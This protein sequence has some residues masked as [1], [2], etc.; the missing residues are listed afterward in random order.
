MRCRCGSGLV[1]SASATPYETSSPLEAITPSLREVVCAFWLPVGAGYIGSVLTPALLARGWH[2]TVLD[3]FADGNPYLAQCCSDPNFEPGARRYSRHAR[4]G[5]AAEGKPTFVIPLAALVGEALSARDQ[6]GAVSLNRD[7]VVDMMKRLSPVGSGWCFRTA[8]AATASATGQRLLH[9]G[10]AAA[11]GVAVWAHE[12]R[13]GGGGA[14]DR[15]RGISVQ[16]ATVFGMSPRMRLDLLVNDFTWRAVNDR[17]VI[18]FEAHF[19][20]NYIHVRDVVKAFVHA[21]N[22]Y[23]RYVG[24][25]PYKVGLSEANLTKLPEG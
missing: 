11:A 24:A 4:G 25:R 5:A 7:A 18:L 6:I 12:G 21:V 8:T 23:D 13:G 3:T 2:V 22:N 19:R 1:A 15:R 10:I 16:L 9:R 20:R 17:A 14:G